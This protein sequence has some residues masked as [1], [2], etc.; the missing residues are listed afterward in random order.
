[1]TPITYT[2]VIS[3]K[4]IKSPYLKNIPYQIMCNDRFTCNLRSG[5][6][7]RQGYYSDDI[8]HVFKVIA[9]TE[10]GVL[11]SNEIFIPY[12]SDNVAFEIITER[13]E[14]NRYALKIIQIPFVLPE[15]IPL[16]SL[17][18][19]DNGNIMYENPEG[20]IQMISLQ[21]A[22]DGWKDY[23]VS[24]TTKPKYIGNHTVDNPNEL[25]FYMNRPINI[26]FFN[27]SDKDLEKWKEILEKARDLGYEI[28][29]LDKD[30]YI[31]DIYKPMKEKILLTPKNG[32]EEETSED[33]IL[34]ILFYRNK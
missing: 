27:A 28:F 34:K 13:D 20:K 10:D 30:Q 8:G 32:T 16:S 2:Y 14:H 25:C 3:I 26:N 15:V 12:E 29:D 17:R 5:E 21:A 1:M 9:N 11:T 33:D 7:Y 24:Y 19:I 4:R 31:E 6:T 23:M 22:Y 18:G